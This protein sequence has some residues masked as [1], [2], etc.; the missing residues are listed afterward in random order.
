M[1]TKKIVKKVTKKTNKKEI[2]GSITEKRIAELKKLALKN[3]NVAIFIQTEDK[4]FTSG[5]LMIRNYNPSKL[6]YVLMKEVHEKEPAMV[7][8]ALLSFLKDTK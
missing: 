3:K 4:E 1:N 7:L 8:N 6:L 5:T 2:W